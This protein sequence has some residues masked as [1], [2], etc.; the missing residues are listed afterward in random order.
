[1]PQAQEDPY[2]IGEEV[3]LIPFRG[4]HLNRRRFRVLL[5]G[6]SFHT[7]ESEENRKLLACSAVLPPSSTRK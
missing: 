5:H 6:T 3:G 7:K 1:M 2:H 4:E